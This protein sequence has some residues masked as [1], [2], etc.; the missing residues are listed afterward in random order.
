MSHGVITWY[1]LLASIATANT[2]HDSSSTRRGFDHVALNGGAAVGDGFGFGLGV[3]ESVGRGLGDGLA[4]GGDA[5][6]LGTSPRALLA[7]GRDPSWDPVTA[8]NA[9][10]PPIPVTAAKTA[11]MTAFCRSS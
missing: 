5:V 4:A 6:D 7:A 11:T 10:T 3:G 9:S 2:P 8:S 1:R